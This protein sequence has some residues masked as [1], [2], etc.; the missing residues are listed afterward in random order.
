MRMRNKV[1]R[2]LSIKK[3][4]KRNKFYHNKG[5]FHFLWGVAKKGDTVAG[6]DMTS[7]P[8]LNKTT[9]KPKKKYLKINNPNPAD[10]SDSYINKKLRKDVRI[11]FDDSNNVRLT[12]KKKWKASKEDVKVVKKLDRN[13]L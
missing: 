5:S 3:W 2:P 13:K 4:Q 8:S 11:H 12:E 7:H 1:E 9:G 10:D 6:H